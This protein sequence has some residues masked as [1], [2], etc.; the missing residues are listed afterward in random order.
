MI[1]PGRGP[2]KCFCP[3]LRRNR[4]NFLFWHFYLF[5]AVLGEYKKLDPLNL[6]IRLPFEN[7]Q[8]LHWAISQGD[9]LFSV[10]RPQIIPSF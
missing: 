3:L 4:V 8:L 9:G 6:F 7:E 5:L 10:S 1:K 2:F